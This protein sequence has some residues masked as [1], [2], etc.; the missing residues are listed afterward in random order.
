MAARTVGFVVADQ[1]QARLERLVERFGHGNR[2]EFLRQ[3]IRV[4]SVQDR[5]ERLRL[6]QAR[7]AGD[8]GKEITPDEV[9]DLVAKTLAAATP[10]TS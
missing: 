7:A 4:M 5:A 2:S 8:V 9:N 10:P 1:D 6:A 3:A